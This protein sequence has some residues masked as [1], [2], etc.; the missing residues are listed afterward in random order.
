VSGAGGNIVL[1]T[2]TNLG[3][4]PLGNFGG[5]TQT[6]ALQ[7]GS[8]AKGAGTQEFYAGTNIPLTTDQ[9]GSPLSNPVNIGAYQGPL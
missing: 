7:K 1:T 6:M 4:A 3:L 2:L 8:E 5:P 9:H